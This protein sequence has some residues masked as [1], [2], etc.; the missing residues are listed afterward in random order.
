MKISRILNTKGRD[1]TT[2]AEDRPVLEV[3]ADLRRRGIGAVVVVDGD[4]TV[5]GIVSERDI[6]NA[7]ADYGER[8]KDLTVRDL[9]TTGIAMCSPDDDVNDVMRQ[10]SG[11]RFRHVPVIENGDLAGIISMRDL[12]RARMDELER[13]TEALQ[14]YI[15]G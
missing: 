8:L 5:A 9:M 7:V 3:V 14:H 6:V 13:E 1:V 2:V 12:V 15:S 4:G 10:M 11:G